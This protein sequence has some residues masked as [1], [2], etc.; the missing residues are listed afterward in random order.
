MDA[1]T[2]K[3]LLD[4]ALAHPY[5][6]SQEIESYRYREGQVIITLFINHEKEGCLSLTIQSNQAA[7]Q[8]DRILTLLALP[9]CRFVEKIERNGYF[10]NRYQFDLPSETEEKIEE[11]VIQPS[12]S[13]SVKRRRPAAWQEIDDNRCHICHRELSDPLS[14][15]VKIGSV[16]RKNIEEAE[17]FDSNK[18]E[19]ISEDEL[20]KLWNFHNIYE[21]RRQKK[22]EAEAQKSQKPIEM[23][24]LRA[25]LPFRV[26]PIMNI[27]QT[28]KSQL[29]KPRSIKAQYSNS[30]VTLPA[31]K[32]IYCGKITTNYWYYNGKTQTCEC[33]DCAAAKR[34]NQS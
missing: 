6:G 2:S 10:V 24:A 23:A 9:N 8:F 16:C 1:L 19:D 15:K 22:A 28:P 20:K 25:E 7:S 5:D 29:A 27:S 26:P 21:K 13:F 3:S 30:S 33:R 32:C 17:G 18:W 14:L 31:G 12:S 4:F 34:E 11:K